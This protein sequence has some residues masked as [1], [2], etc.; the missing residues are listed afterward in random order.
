VESNGFSVGVEHLDGTVTLRPSGELDLAT[1]PVLEQALDRVLDG[2]HVV[3]LDLSGLTFA[4]C[5]GLEPVRWALRRSPSDR[6]RL[7][8]ARPLV[9]RVLALTGVQE[10][11]N[12]DG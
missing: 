9:E 2:G 3:V 5:A 12:V 8:G 1:A 10:P 6:I 11:L 7:V 4:D